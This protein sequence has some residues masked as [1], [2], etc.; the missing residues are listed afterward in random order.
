MPTEREY[1]VTLRDKS[2]AT[3]FITQMTDASFSSAEISNRP[4][5]VV[6]ERPF[7][8]R[9]TH[10][11]LTDDEANALRNDPRVLAVELLPTERGF[12]KVLLGKNSAQFFQRDNVGISATMRNW[13]L[14]RHTKVNTGYS[15]IQITAD[16][17][18]SKNGNGV[19]LVVV[20]SGIIPGHPEWST[21]FDGTGPSRLQEINWHSV[22]GVPGSEAP[23]GGYYQ[24]TYGHGSHC[25]SLAAGSQHGFAKGANIYSLRI[26]SGYIGS[27]YYGEIDSNVVFDIVKAFHLQKPISV[28][29]YRRPTVCTNSWG[30][31]MTYPTSTPMTTTWRGTTYTHVGRNS[32]YGQVTVNHGVRIT[33]VDADVVDCINAGVIMVG[34]AGNGRHKIDVPGGIDWNNSYNSYGGFGVNYHQG[35][36]P[37]APIGSSSINGS[38]L[39]PSMICVGAL[40]NTPTEQKAIFSDTGP[41]VD[42]YAAGVMNIGAYANKAY[43]T[44]AVADSRNS[45]FYL[46][47]IS[48]TSMAA[49][50]VAGVACLMA[51]MRPE[52]NN[53]QIRNW[54][55]N[56]SNKDTL[57]QGTSMAYSNNRHL[58]GGQRRVLKW[59]YNKEQPFVSSGISIRGGAE[60]IL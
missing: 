58:Q 6:N 29:G 60:I 28:N 14:Y 25:A 44:N 10:Y 40:D 17:T 18:Y 16:Y 26:F 59:P 3:D 24:D 39:Q 35:S 19:D 36:S 41:G 49:P 33:S 30:W 56:L 53:S 15:G 31:R 54:L 55:I 23:I 46:N 9:N 22:T 8:D 7:S 12:E 37:T 34:A 50:N 51:E 48:G 32:T 2:D 21:N 45:G 38:V 43:Y 13:G 5:I 4:V 57:V 27:E 47:K 20:D 52:Y 1:I 42:I 11:A